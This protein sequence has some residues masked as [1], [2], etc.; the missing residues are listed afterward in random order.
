M[1]RVVFTRGAT[2]TGSGWVVLGV[3]PTGSLGLGGKGDRVVQALG[4][5]PG[6]PLGPFELSELF[7]EIGFGPALAVVLHGRHPLP[8]E[9]SV[10]EYR[11][12]NVFHRS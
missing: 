12:E 9:G 4:A 5:T 6:D 8:A 10:P 11:F 2:S 3:A 1:P 7:I